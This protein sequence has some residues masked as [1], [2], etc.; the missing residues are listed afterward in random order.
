[1]WA[2]KHSRLSFRRQK[3]KIRHF[4]VHLIS[5]EFHIFHEKMSLRLLSCIFDQS[6]CCLYV[7]ICWDDAFRWDGGHSRHQTA[8]DGDCSC[9]EEHV[10]FTHWTCL[11]LEDGDVCR[12]VQHFGPERFWQPLSRSRKWCSCSLEDES[13]YFWWCLYLS[14]D[15]NLRTDFT[16]LS[17]LLVKTLRKHQEVQCSFILWL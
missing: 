1:M 13:W 2:V 8:R 14:S 16:F 6:S 12:L 3:Y 10:Q 9:Y 7:G 5:S 15:A 4:L 11:S 17:L